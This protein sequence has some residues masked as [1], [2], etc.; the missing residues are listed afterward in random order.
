MKKLF[1]VPLVAL[2]SVAFGLTFEEAV[3]A[4][5][6]RPDAISAQ[7]ELLNAES[8]L[9]RTEAD[10]LALRVDRLQA[11]QAVELAAVEE[12]Q[13]RVTAVQDLAGAYGGVL[14]AREQLELAETARELAETGVEIARIRLAN[15]SATEL[16][17]RDAEVALDEASAGAATAGSGL[18]LAVSNLEG[19]IGREVDPATLEPLTEDLLPQLPTLE[20]VLLASERVPQLLQVEH[21]LELAGAAVDMLD[22]SYASEAQIEQARTRLQTTEQLAAEARRGLQ[23]QARNLH[24]MAQNARAQLQVEQ[25]AYANALERHEFERQRLASGL[26]SEIAFRQA[27]LQLQQAE[28][29]LLQA[30]TDAMVALLELSAGTLV[31]LDGPAVLRGER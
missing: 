20:A 3:S 8:T 16:D 24:L 14:V 28:I 12:Q 23:L 27:G 21:G 5:P 11:Q 25:E 29:S 30:Q 1:L 2:L 31:T 17:V 26:I 4:A 10:P 18:R 13:A 15:G 9:L 22:P 6:G 7:L 19:M